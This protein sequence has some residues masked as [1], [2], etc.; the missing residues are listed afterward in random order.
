M[1]VGFRLV[2]INLI[3]Q[4]VLRVV[5]ASNST[6]LS[7]QTIWISNW[8]VHSQISLWKENGIDAGKIMNILLEKNVMLT[9]EAL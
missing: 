2:L 6:N 5:P 8:I 1:Y 3:S 7:F 4:T 9:C